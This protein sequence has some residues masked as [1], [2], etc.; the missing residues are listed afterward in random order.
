MNL[1]VIV[2]LGLTLA[3]VFDASVGATANNLQGIGLTASHKQIIY[4][5]I[6]SERGQSLAGGSRLGIG[7]TIP[8]SVMLNAVPISVKEQVGLLRDFKFI[9]VTDNKILLVDP[10]TRKIVDIITKQDAGR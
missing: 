9:K 2:T 7:D 1:S 6:A 3:L 8:D 10:A 4:D 5:R